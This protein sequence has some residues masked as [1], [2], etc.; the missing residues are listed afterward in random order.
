M[1]SSNKCHIIIFFALLAWLP[2]CGESDTSE[3]DGADA[4]EVSDAA[5]P[6][7]NTD[8]SEPT[9]PT[10]E[11]EPSDPTETTD[12]SET[13]EPSGTNCATYLE[14]VDNCW[15]ED[16][17]NA[18]A[19]SIACADAALPEALDAA[20]AYYECMDNC[21]ESTSDNEALG[22][23]YEQECGPLYNLCIAPPECIAGCA[24][25]DEICGDDG[26]LSQRN[27]YIA[28]GTTHRLKEMLTQAF[29]QFKPHMLSTP[30][31]E[32][33]ERL[34]IYSDT[35]SKGLA[36]VHLTS[37][38][39]QNSLREHPN[40][41]AVYPVYQ[42][43]R[44]HR[45]LATNEVIAHLPGQ[46]RDRVEAL[47]LP[48]K[49]RIIRPAHGLPFTWLLET[50]SMPATQASH[51]IL[52]L[53]A[54]WA[55]PNF[56]RQYQLRHTPNDPFFSSQWHHLNTGETPQTLAGADL[57]TT[58]A[59]DQTQ[60]VAEV[61][62]AINDDGVD[63]LQSDL[64]FARNAEGEILSVNEP[65]NI[66]DALS[67]GCCQHGTSVAGVVAA[68][69]DNEV[70]T[71]G[72]CPGCSLIPVWTDYTSPNEDL[73]VAETFTAALEQDAWVINNSWGPPD[74]NPAVI[75]SPAPFEPLPDVIGQALQEAAENGRSGKGTVV[76][77]AAGNGNEDVAS[78]PYVTHPTT[79]GIAAVNGRGIK[80]S[81]SD[82]GDS[83]WVAAPSSGNQLAPGIVTSDAHG[84]FGYENSGNPNS[85]DDTGDVNFNFGGT[86][87][88]TPAV[89]GVVGL[90]LSVNSDL[91]A[92]QVKDI[93]R[94]TSRKI[95][96]ARGEYIPDNEGFLRSPFY[97][98]GLVDAHAAVRAAS[99][100]CSADTEDA[101]IPAAD[102][103]D[104]PLLN[105]REICNGIDDDCNGTT[106]EGVCP[107]VTEPGQPCDL[108]G[109]C[110]NTCTWLNHDPL[111]A[112]LPAC[113]AEQNCEEGYNCLGG[114][115]VPGSERLSPAS[116]EVCDGYDND[117]NG[118]V[119]EDVCEQSNDA[120]CEYT[121]QCDTT[122]GDTVCVEGFCAPVCSTTEDCDTGVECQ[123]VASQYGES[124][125]TSICAPSF[126]TGL[127]CIEACMFL[128]EN[129][130]APIFQGIV[131]CITEA[132]TC[133]DAI[134]C[135]P[136]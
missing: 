127:T 16:S 85:P 27:S 76:L 2:S 66:E 68:I 46:Q 55:S 117:L 116:T 97:G 114:I 115:C 31:I 17:D 1:R 38:S 53:G 51:E 45:L 124:T 64:N 80:S 128:K 4:S 113:D 87:S 36:V 54:E 106:D 99:I 107:E 130:P 40:V 34:E 91:T 58:H 14:C 75:E 132:P 71:A 5:D 69:A 62:I 94:R 86:S 122:N 73:A 29:I 23:C 8:V 44:S 52:N 65:D 61:K 33:M 111:P 26:P 93:L 22:L 82:F 112:C 42:S 120:T 119:D 30:D 95:D 12:P 78:D 83:V 81:Y 131:N 20:N 126:N 123:V 72:V 28:G 48:L 110:L 84:D 41:Q 10:S 60:G 37:K 49:M 11:T 103:S 7:D 59:W 15:L 50:Q 70:G 90:M 105:V 88:A 101:C 13:I 96:R 57:R 3:T 9:D 129:A 102:C 18:E 47:L 77:F 56:L 125:D 98:Y 67:Q 118:E 104:G 134:A 63:L 32:G 109:G 79:L 6:T 21:E 92:A 19:C 35:I 24:H 43:A 100:G 25:Y 89:A 133:E 121:A 136:L 135:V 74:G 39:I 108:T